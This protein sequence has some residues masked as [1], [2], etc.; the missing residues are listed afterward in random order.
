MTLCRPI[1]SIIPNCSLT[2][3]WIVLSTLYSTVAGELLPSSSSLTFAFS[4]TKNYQYKPTSCLSNTNHSRFV[5]CCAIKFYSSLN[6]TNL[7]LLY[8]SSDPLVSDRTWRPGNHKAC[9]LTL[10]EDDIVISPIPDDKYIYTLYLPYSYVMCADKHRLTSTVTLTT[11]VIQFFTRQL[12]QRRFDRFTSR[13]RLCHRHGNLR[14]SDECKWDSSVWSHPSSSAKSI[15]TN[16]GGSSLVRHEFYPVARKLQVE[17]RIR[18]PVSFS[19][20]EIV[21][22]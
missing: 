3:I 14:E 6:A 5:S 21:H 4:A 22:L 10:G 7:G 12:H 15:G 1:S 13:C 2:M 17:Q 20:L 19:T 9:S 8:T 11:D 16:N 18:K